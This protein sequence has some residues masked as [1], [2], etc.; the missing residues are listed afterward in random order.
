MWNRSRSRPRSYRLAPLCSHPDIT[1]NTDSALG[2]DSHPDTLRVMA[3]A[4]RCP[5]HRRLVHFSSQP[6]DIAILRPATNIH[7]S[8]RNVMP[9]PHDNLP[10]V[11]SRGDS[12]RRKSP[13]FCKTLR[14]VPTTIHVLV[15]PAIAQRASFGFF[16]RVLYSD[17]RSSMF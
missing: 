7:R 13:R 3:K 12:V 6:P 11:T 2:C 4:S 17:H 14:T 1:G 16:P 10:Q 15:S 5:I 9:I 8:Q